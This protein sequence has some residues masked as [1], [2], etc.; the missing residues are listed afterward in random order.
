MTKEQRSIYARTVWEE[1]LKRRGK[2][3]P[4]CCSP[5]EFDYLAKLMD[6]EVPLRV[7]L[8]GLEDM[9]VVKGLLY[10]RPG[11]EEAIRQWESRQVL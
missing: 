10:A 6:R 3:Y 9:R 11:I 7:V 5:A 2:D 4:D 8:R 1:V